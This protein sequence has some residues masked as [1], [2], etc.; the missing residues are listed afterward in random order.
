MF[1]ATMEMPSSSH[2][3]KLGALNPICS[4][5][6]LNK[7]VLRIKFSNIVIMGFRRLT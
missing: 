1:L 7:E 4:L 2:F 5:Q 6:P 3:A